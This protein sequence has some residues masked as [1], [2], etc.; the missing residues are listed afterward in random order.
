M[1]RC[2]EACDFLLEQCVAK[3]AHDNL[4][5]L[6]VMCGVEAEKGSG[7][8]V[9]SI[10]PLAGDKGFE[11]ESSEMS[12]HRACHSPGPSASLGSPSSGTKDRAPLDSTIF[13]P[14][15]PYDSNPNDTSTDSNTNV[16]RHLE[17][18][19]EFQ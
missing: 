17:F 1:V 2:A 10:V 19:K 6:L 3:G 8:S 4:S 16:S 15:S 11:G 12:P 13:A 14:D 18:N 5:A 9:R 7:E